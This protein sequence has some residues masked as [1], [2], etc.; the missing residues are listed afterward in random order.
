MLTVYVNQQHWNRRM[1]S[2]SKSSHRCDDRIWFVFPVSLHLCEQG[3]EAVGLSR[4][5][6]VQLCSLCPA[7]RRRNLKWRTW[8]V[9]WDL[10]H[11][12][13]LA[14]KLH[15]IVTPFV[16]QRAISLHFNLPT[17]PPQ[18]PHK[19]DLL[20]KHRHTEMH[21]QV[22]LHMCILTFKHA[23]ECPFRCFLSSFITC[24]PFS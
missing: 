11:A 16:S 3:S 24:V 19:P 1:S 13:R 22:P 9:P 20:K 23:P 18:N 14:A 21:M 10:T 2:D 7:Y 4:S 12:P 8:G 15:I 6:A 17:P 5:L